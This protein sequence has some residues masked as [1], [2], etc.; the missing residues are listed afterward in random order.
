MCQALIVANNI[1]DVI[2]GRASTMDPPKGVEPK[3]A[4]KKKSIKKEPPKKPSNKKSVV[5]EAPR[6]PSVTIEEPMS[7]VWPIERQEVPL[8]EAVP[9]SIARDH[10]ILCYRLE[11]I[12]IEM[13]LHS[14]NVV[15]HLF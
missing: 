6:M 1:L 15:I 14:I 7:M 13:T 2:A 9:P 12:G 3:D 10:Q 4:A 8:D 5:K 11:L